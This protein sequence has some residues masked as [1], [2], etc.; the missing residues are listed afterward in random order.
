MLQQPC[1]SLLNKISEVVSYIQGPGNL[2]TYVTGTE[3]RMMSSFSGLLLWLLVIPTAHGQ[4]GHGHRRPQPRNFVLTQNYL[5]SNLTRGF[6]FRTVILFFFFFFFL[7]SFS[8]ML[9]WFPRQQTTQGA[10]TQPTD[11]SITWIE[12]RPSRRDWSRSFVTSYS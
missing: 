10:G 12:P 4:R 5:P 3:G 6:E 8:P 9:I 11:S 1:G 2:K 7:E